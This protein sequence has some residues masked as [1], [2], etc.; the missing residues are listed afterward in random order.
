M[1]IS[2]AVCEESKADLHI[3]YASAIF[4]AFMGESEKTLR[5]YF[6]EAE[7]K[8]DANASVVLFFDEVWLSDKD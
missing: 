7:Q 2:Q 8:E 4:G 6:E 5:A 3:V 1:N